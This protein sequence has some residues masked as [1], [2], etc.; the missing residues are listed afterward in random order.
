MKVTV[1][2][3]RKLMARLLKGDDLLPALEKLC[4]ELDIRLGEIR[5]IGAVSRARFG[6]YHQAQQKYE[7][8]ELSRPLEIVSLLGNISLKDGRP[9]VHGH[10]VLA[11]EKGGA[12]GGH[13][14]EGTVI[15]ACEVAIQEYL[16]GEPL[17]RQFDEDSGLF[18][19]SGGRS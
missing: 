4:G 14:A 2:P 6:Y 9:F 16:S 15:F 7:F 13:L 17:V 3:G 11:D 5:A 12:F 19:W 8:L 10:I 18:L 1:T